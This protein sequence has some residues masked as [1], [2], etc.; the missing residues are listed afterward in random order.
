MSNEQDKPK[1]ISQ[2]LRIDWDSP[3]LAWTSS[4]AS[5]C[6]FPADV[7]TDPHADPLQQEADALEALIDRF[8]P[9]LTEVALP[10][11]DAAQAI[12]AIRNRAMPL[13]RAL[14]KEIKRLKNEA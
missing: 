2:S 6:P 12:I 14:L 11:E 9:N 3:T 5:P 7:L 1:R 10:T 4:S 8:P 13:I